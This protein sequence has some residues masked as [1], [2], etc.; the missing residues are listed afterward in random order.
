[1]AGHLILQ[2]KDSQIIGK[3][4]RL[5]EESGAG[6]KVNKNDNGNNTSVEISGSFEAPDKA[7]DVI[8][9]PH[10]IQSQAWL[11]FLNGKNMIGIA[12]TET[13]KTPAFLHPALLHTDGR[14]CEERTGLVGDDF[15]KRIAL[16]D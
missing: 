2:E 11:V 14:P 6:I 12:Q 10:P 5:E 13:D 9:E 3:I 1:M 7:R 15:Y 8:I 16:T 4:R